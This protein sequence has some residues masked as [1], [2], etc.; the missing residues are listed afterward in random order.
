MRFSSNTTSTKWVHQTVA[1]EGGEYY[2][3]SGYALKNDPNVRDAFLRVSFYSSDDGLGS[4]IAAADS[5]ETLS[6]DD[7]NFRRLSTAPVQ[8]P[9]DARTARLRLMLRP[10][11]DAN[12]EVYFDGL[13]FVRVP[14]P[15]DA[16]TSPSPHPGATTPVATETPAHTSASPISSADPAR[17]GVEIAISETY[18]P[19]VALAAGSTPARLANVGPSFAPTGFGSL[20]QSRSDRVWL[21]AVALALPVVGLASVG[22]WELHRAFAKKE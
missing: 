10:W 14:E 1:V 17:A 4:A 21:V 12:A 2:E 13:S 19:A 18:V 15:L 22:A 16:V 3:A 6:D 7:P 9:P 5:L 11:S 20:E 8:T